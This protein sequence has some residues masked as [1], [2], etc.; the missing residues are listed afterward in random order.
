M[1]KL[2]IL[3]ALLALNA[4][5]SL[6]QSG[7]TLN[8]DDSLA[9]KTI[10]D[11][12]ISPDG[13]FVAYQMQTTN[14]KDNEFHTEIWVVD[15]ATG[16]NFQLTDAKSSSNGPDWSPDG[17]WIAFTSERTGDKS[18]IY[19]ISPVGGE[20]IQLTSAETGVRGF[21]W[22]PDSKHIAFA[23][24]D[25]D[26][27]AKKDRVE[28]FGDI[29]VV[30]E[31]RTMTG[32]W[33][34]DVPSGQIEKPVEAK[35]LTDTTSYTVGD[36][37]WSPDSTRIAFAGSA[38]PDPDDSYTSQ[39][40]V[41]TIADKSVKK[42]VSDG[43]SQDP[44][45]SPDGRQIAYQA[46]NGNKYFYYENWQIGVVDAN[47]GT[48]RMTI[49]NF[50]E[51][52]NLR[53]WSPQGI[54]FSGLQKTFEHLYLLDPET[55]KYR[56]ISSPDD[57]LA[58]SFSFTRDFKQAAFVSG[59]STHLS[60]I[61]VTS[62]DSFQ[63]KKLTDM[64]DQLKG[65][66]LAKRELVQWKSKDG[67]EI[68]GVLIKPPDYD[69]SKKYPLL[70]VIHGGPTGVSRAAF[71][72]DHYYP[73]EMFAAK[74][75][76]VLQP[77]YRGSA[78][79]GAKFRALNVRNLG[80]GDYWDVISGVDYLIGK[81]MVD[82]KLVASMGW[83]EGGYISAFIT[84]SSDRFKAVSVGAGISDWVTYYVNTDIHPFTRQYLH[85]TPW[86]D[87]EIYRKTSPMSYIK[88]ARTP[89]LIQQGSNDPRVP[90]PNS[91]LLYQALKDKGI[92][93]RFV[94]LKGFGHGITKPKQQRAVMEQ[95][96]LWFGHYIWG[97]KLPEF[98]VVQ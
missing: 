46:A 78:G 30:G 91:F 6:A 59:D 16:R 28:K 66:T 35:H 47:G 94:L 27:K 31:D 48:P 80:V 20:A 4:Q 93:V 65:Y 58:S 8:I 54:L 53:I 75:A 34:A 24:A 7:K 41:L 25:P 96:L 21:R 97:D 71:S 87:P 5:A 62:L 18:Q 23:A 32:L 72:P 14:W 33:L 40:Y 56:R 76:L 17:K 36:F 49:E 37:A 15:V 42:I 38:S 60:E 63:P 85:A 13:K 77:N 12:Q 50:D 55:K 88:S 86:D 90:V 10:S 57:Y 29:T 52:P 92:P 44:I 1:K 70:V 81:G 79:Y 84:T 51:D 64:S 19:L 11:P 3:F 89:T 45:W 9:L 83:S 68:E 67:A 61:Y 22:S 39:I 98:S 95:N 43:P 26:S 82:P 69:P 73:I 74:G 2:L